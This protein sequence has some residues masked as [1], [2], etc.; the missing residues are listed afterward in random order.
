MSAEWGGPLASSKVTAEENKY[1]ASFYWNKSCGA[2]KEL[3]L[4]YVKMC[5]LDW[6]G[7]SV[8]GMITN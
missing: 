2:T 1:V 6:D 3:G 8:G 4:L 5:Y 7:S